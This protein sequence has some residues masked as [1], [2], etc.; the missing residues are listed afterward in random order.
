[1]SVNSVHI[2]FYVRVHNILLLGGPPPD[3]AA[4][5]AAAPRAAGAMA[6]TP[7]VTGP[8]LTLRLQE[9]LGPARAQ[10]TVTAHDQRSIL[11]AGT[12]KFQLFCMTNRL[13]FPIFVFKMQARQYDELVHIRQ[14]NKH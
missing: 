10:G 4:A 5:A 12:I 1:M 11:E 6:P 3:H 9:V 7:K 2:Q 8:Q 13:E 14:G